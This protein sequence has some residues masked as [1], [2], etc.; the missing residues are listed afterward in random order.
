MSE[1]PSD[2]KAQNNEESQ[3]FNAAD[4]EGDQVREVET[5]GGGHLHLE[6]T[7]TQTPQERT[8]ALLP[9]ATSDGTGGGT[10]ES[11]PN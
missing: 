7:D 9:D 2:Q 5:S 10:L 4:G 8:K 11:N 3:Q 1:S 6:D